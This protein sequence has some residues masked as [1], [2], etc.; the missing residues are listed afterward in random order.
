MI[1]SPPRFFAARLGVRLGAARLGAEKIPNKV[2]AG[3][4]GAPG[5]YQNRG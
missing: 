1:K 2:A 3:R 4:L 5:K